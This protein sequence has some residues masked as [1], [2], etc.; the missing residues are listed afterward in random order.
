MACLQLYTPPPPKEMCLYPP[1]HNFK[2]L[3]MTLIF[4][5]GLDYG[6][7]TTVMYSLVRQVYRDSK[8]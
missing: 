6:T 2:F 8:Q 7:V 5:I 4:G 3:K 1:P